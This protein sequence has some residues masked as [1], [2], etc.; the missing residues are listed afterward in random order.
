MLKI[1][2]SILSLLS[3]C[4][5]L[6]IVNI[7]SPTSASPFGILI[8]FALI[9]LSSFGLA[10][11]FIYFFSKIV[12]FTSRLFVARKPIAVVDFKKACTFSLIIAAAPVMI[13]GLKS[14]GA[15]E[16]YGYILVLLFVVI[17]LAYMSKRIH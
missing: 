5:L 1:I 16:I 6:V 3:L 15:N 9:Y 4:L 11:F 8:V 14:V 17:S 2:I 7:T 12:S 10:T 13:L